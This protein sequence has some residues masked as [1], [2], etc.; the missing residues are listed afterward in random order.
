MP[1]PTEFVQIIEPKPGFLRIDWREIWLYRE[2]FGFLVWKDVKVKY[3]Q[4]LLGVAWAVLV[5]FFQMVV[6]TIVFGKFGKLPS[7][8]LPQP[9]F[10][11]SALLPWAY[12]STALTASSNSLVSNSALL[13]KI[14]VPRVI[15]PMVP[16]ITGMLNLFLAS[17]IL[18]LMMLYYNIIPPA[19]AVLFPAFIFIAFGTAFGFGLFFASLN[20]KYRDVRMAMPFV[21]QLWMF[22]SVIL[23]FSAIPEKYGNL[24]YLYG[25]NPMA[26]VIEGARWC[27]LKPYMFVEKTVG[28]EKIREAVDAPWTLVL[29]GLP[30]MLAILVGG[31]AYFNYVEERFADIV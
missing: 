5:P 30:V 6:F 24:R 22:C 12:F 27:L 4:T 14:Y 29:V 31:L 15:L 7:D 9:I 10:Y 19:T 3:K 23:P 1:E 8:G 13:T 21:T 28:G 16:C 20:V 11:Y 25:L 18:V 26:G 2:L 17:V